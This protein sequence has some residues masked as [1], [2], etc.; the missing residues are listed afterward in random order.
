MGKNTLNASGE[1]TQLH[2]VGPELL[3]RRMIATQTIDLDSFF[4]KDVTTSGSF[5]LRQVKNITF[6]KLLEA[7]P[8]PT[9]LIDPSHSI[10]FANESVAKIGG[11][12]GSIIG[13]SFSSLFPTPSEVQNATAVLNQIFVDR[14][15]HVFE[16]L[17]QL[18]SK[19]LWCRVNLRSLRFRSRRSVLAIIEDLTAEK[20]KL[21]I[22]QK[23]QQLVQVFP[24]GIAEFSLHRPVAAD[25]AL[26]EVLKSVSQAHLVGGNHEFARIHGH[27]GIESVK[28]SPLNT[29]FPYEDAYTGFYLG[30][31]QDHFPIRSFENEEYDSQ[32]RHRFFENTLV[33]NV[34]NDYLLGFWAMRQDITHRKQAEEALRSA[35]DR[36]EEK[37]KERTGEL[38]KANEHL[39]MEIAER[40]KAEQVL[41]KLVDELQEALAKV[42]TLS[43]LLPICASCKKIRDDK[44]YWTQVEVFVRDHS[45]ADFTH[46]ICPECAAKLYPEFYSPTS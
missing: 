22:N 41:A 1:G 9:L 34:K 43:G 32:G 6:G 16:G 8:I 37:V 31:I 4:T 15:T 45:E 27:H 29:M 12:S 19:M 20:K 42:K 17:I 18:G 28:G 13:V 23:Y 46:S 5:D 36:L 35:R 3:Q 10:V 30:W 44:G 2:T 14:K 40:E 38:L 7:I 11:D 33:G 24:I 21:I 26:D 25:R 39:V